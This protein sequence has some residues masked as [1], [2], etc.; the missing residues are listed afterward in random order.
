VVRKRGWVSSG[1]KGEELKVGKG[2]W[3][4]GRKRG[5]G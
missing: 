2:G 5:I 3:V 1:L 4:K